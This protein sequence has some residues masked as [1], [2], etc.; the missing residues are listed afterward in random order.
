MCEVSGRG[1]ERYHGESCESLPESRYVL[2]WVPTLSPVSGVA[3]PTLTRPVLAAPDAAE[4]VHD[5]LAA[6]NR[7]TQPVLPPHPASSGGTVVKKAR[8]SQVRTVP[9]PRSR[10]G[11]KRGGSSFRRSH[12]V[13]ARHLP[14]RPAP[15][16]ATHRRP[17]P[18]AP[19]WARRQMPRPYHRRVV[20]SSARDTRPYSTAP[21]FDS[22][23]DLRLPL[24]RNVLRYHRNCRPRLP[25]RG[26]AAVEARGT[27]LARNATAFRAR[28][29]RRLGTDAEPP[30][31]RGRLPDWSG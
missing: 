14:P 17:D 18:V 26:P 23:A 24:S 15:T 28:R 22:I 2:R 5:R 19:Q 16:V 3:S 13:G 25:V 27:L 20:R 9:L 4:P 30:P 11:R 8:A 10:L 7:H 12:L 29:S 1:H 21:P 31:R 6:Q